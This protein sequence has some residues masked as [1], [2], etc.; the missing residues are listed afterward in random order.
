MLKVNKIAYLEEEKKHV[1]VKRKGILS[2]RIVKTFFLHF[3]Y[4]I[5]CKVLY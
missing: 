4:S 5:L 1:S 3:L 2:V